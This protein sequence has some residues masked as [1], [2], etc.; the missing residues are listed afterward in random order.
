M[1]DAT[2][3]ATK[4]P[5]SRTAPIA[6]KQRSITDAYAGALRGLGITANSTHVF[7]TQFAANCILRHHE[8]SSRIGICFS[9]LKMVLFVQIER[10][11]ELEVASDSQTH[12]IPELS[13]FACDGSVSESKFPLQLY[14][15]PYLVPHKMLEEYTVDH[16]IP[17]K[18]Y[19]YQHLSA[20][21]TAVVKR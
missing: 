13:S 16:E 7:A 8:Q 15:T 21:A 14:P 9:I 4:P 6:T 2:I 12:L 3:T 17:G 5:F 11:Q 10:N 20:A 18:Q 19:L 1:A